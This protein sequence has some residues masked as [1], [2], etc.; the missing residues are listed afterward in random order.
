MTFRV[1]SSIIYAITTPI[2]H[3]YAKST[4]KYD[5]NDQRPGGSSA[6]RGAAAFK[7][8]KSIHFFAADVSRNSLQ[9]LKNIL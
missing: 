1:M 7:K 2:V 4:P 8:A 6:P 5:H 9:T 3:F